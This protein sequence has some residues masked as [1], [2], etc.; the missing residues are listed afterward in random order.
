MLTA[1]L[2]RAPIRVRDVGEMQSRWWLTHNSPT[3]LASTCN[4]HLVLASKSN[5]VKEGSVAV[6]LPLVCWA[7]LH[8]PDEVSHVLLCLRLSVCFVLVGGG[9]G[10]CAAAWKAT[11]ELLSNL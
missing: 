4:Y 1:S 10:F 11:F 8:F 2:C 6:S 7:I 9:T 3:F 5:I